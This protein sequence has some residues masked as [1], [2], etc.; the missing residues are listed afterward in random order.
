MF[1]II[2]KRNARRLGTPSLRARFGF[3]YSGYAISF[4]GGELMEMGRKFIMSGFVLF[5]APGS[6]VRVA[7]ALLVSA[8]FLGIQLHH[9]PYEEPSENRVQVIALWGCTITMFIAVLMM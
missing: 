1:L 9:S 8:L 2:L 7:F 5:V 4:Y 6:L 3:L